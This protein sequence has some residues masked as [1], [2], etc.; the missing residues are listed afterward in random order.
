MPR[1]G[2]VAPWEPAL[3]RLPWVAQ[4]RLM[5]EERQTQMMGAGASPSP[6]FWHSREQQ[7]NVCHQP[8][9]AAY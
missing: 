3:G 8:K 9:A 6:V 2:G 1:A 4:I 5:P 7:A